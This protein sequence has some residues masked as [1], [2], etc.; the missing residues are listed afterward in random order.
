MKLWSRLAVEDLKAQIL[1]IA[2]K[3]PKAAV[4]RKEDI[5]ERSKVLIEQPLIGKEGRV[6]GTREFV[7]S[8]LG[9][10][11]VYRVKSASVQIIRCLQDRQQW[12]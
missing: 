5:L 10:I 4:K 2:E 3:D 11:L 12:S 8:G 6:E 1:Y 9:V 7:L